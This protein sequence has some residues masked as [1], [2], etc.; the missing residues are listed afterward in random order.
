[1]VETTV[2]RGL[3]LA[4]VQAD[5]SGDDPLVKQLHSLGVLCVNELWL[6]FCFATFTLQDPRPFALG[7]W[8]VDC[9]D[10]WAAHLH[11]R[12]RYSTPGSEAM[13]TG[14]QVF[15]RLEAARRRRM[16]RA[17]DSQAAPSGA[18]DQAV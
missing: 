16:I 10:F 12:N 17:D 4:V 9:R 5:R 15:E 6:S 2:Y 13:A 3:H 8:R 14:P 18:S 11:W 7:E 1:M